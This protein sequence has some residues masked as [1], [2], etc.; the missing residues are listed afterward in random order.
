M[1]DFVFALLDTSP[2]FAS[3]KAAQSARE[4]SIGFTRFKF[5]GDIIESRDPDELLKLAA[6]TGSRYCLMLEYG[7][8]ISEIWA[9]EKTDTPAACENDTPVGNVLEALA[10][11]SERNRIPA[12]GNISD[13]DQQRPV[14][15]F[16]DMQ[17]CFK[18]GVPDYEIVQRTARSHPVPAHVAAQIISSSD[19]GQDTETATT[20]ETVTNN[21][22]KSVFVWNIE[23]YADI[24]TPAPGFI[25]P[26]SSLYTVAAGF[27]P[28]RILETHGF[29]AVTRMVIFDYSQ[30]GLDHRKRLHEEWDGE[31]YPEFLRRLF[32]SGEDE[33]IHYLLWQG[34]TPENPDWSQMEARWQQELNLW[35]G[36][37]AFKNHWRRFQIME[38]EYLHCD[39]LNTPGVLLDRIRDEDGSL[40]WWSNAF[41]TLD[42]ISKYTAEQRQAIYRRWIASLA[43][44]APSLH[45]YGS[46]CNNLS[47]NG[48]TAREY[49][50]WLTAS[51]TDPLDVLKPRGLN[52]IR[53]KY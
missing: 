14:F 43:N 44:K 3:R 28:N 7:V 26:L 2:R 47:V 20:L 15:Q 38:I 45:L 18:D 12:A 30:K 4:K 40:L 36:E 33:E 11:W 19:P 42:S 49:S 8:F 27:K 34:A 9:P 17:R 48:F 52:R 46:D 10:N 13:D 16:I 24:E 31:D 5:D 41:L 1:S 29:S 37:Q 6:A 32:K 23:S 50:E 51:D 22:R 39:L 53:M 25:R 21:L 35:G